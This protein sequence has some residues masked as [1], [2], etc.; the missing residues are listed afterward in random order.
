[1]ARTTEAAKQRHRLEVRVTPEQDAL[2]RQAADLEHESVTS[3]VLDTVTERARRV[4]ETQSTITLANEAFDRFYAAL[5]EPEV[6]V[7]ELA[8]LFRT[9]PLPRG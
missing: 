5:D 6:I 2:I 8:E 4:I 9:P 1:M 7:P 3:F